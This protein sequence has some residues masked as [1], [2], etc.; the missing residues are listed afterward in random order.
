MNKLQ[1]ITAIFFILAGM[2]SPIIA[3]TVQ[4]PQ[5]VRAAIN[6]YK[7]Q[8]YIG[9]VQD[10]EDYAEKDPTNAIA[11]YYTGIAYMKMGM[12]ERSIDAFTKVTTINSVPV[13]SSYATQALNCMNNDIKPCVYKKYDK[14]DIET[15]L[16]DPAKFFEEKAAEAANAANKKEEVKAEETTDIDR[17]I[18]GVYPDNIHPEANQVLQETRLIQEQE[19]VN[20]ELKKKNK[21]GPKRDK[22]KG[23]A[24]P[25]IQTTKIVSA[26][27]TDKEIADAVRTLSKAGY[28]FTAPQKDNQTP[29][30][31]NVNP[32][33]QLAEQF[34]LQNDAA[35]MAMMFGGR[36]NNRNNSFDT[37]LPLLLMQEQ[38]NSDGSNKKID[39]ELLKAM[40][41]NQMMGDYD[42]G[43]DNDRKR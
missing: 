36:N 34:A 18:N 3:A 2:S 1:K 23:D 6:K 40:L 32:Y 31:Q 28:T 17:L 25:E 16:A 14:E 39:P 10:L 11:Y 4:C 30:N 26:D 35:Q 42:L 12:K 9:C 29:V 5:A 13:L 27:L 37:M 21:S 41:M 19:R 15:M 43:F 38:Q 20:A 22:Q 24:S 33:K 8:D 7:A